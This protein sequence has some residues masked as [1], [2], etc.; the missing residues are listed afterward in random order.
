M[1]LQTYHRPASV[2]EV[3]DLLARSQVNTA[4]VAG[5]TSLIPHLNEQVDEV[6]DLQAVGLDNISQAGNHLTWGTMVRLQTIV[7]DRQTPPLLRQMAQREGPNTL[8]H[9]ATIGGVV[10]GADNES[11]LLAALL[12]F[13]AEVEIQTGQGSQRLPL[14]ELLADVSAALAGGVMTALSF[15]TTGQTA[16]DRVARTPA[17]RPIIAA[18]A[19]RDETGQVRLALCGVAATPVLINPDPTH[20]KATLNPPGDFR[21]SSAYRRQMAV[22]LSQRVLASLSGESSI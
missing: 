15:P 9:A 4:I 19:R 21:G 8:R 22:L 17:D 16:A 3:L 11:E 20:L 7:D 13:A 18:L 12:V 6:V 5:G 2:A 10:A 14:S 1:A